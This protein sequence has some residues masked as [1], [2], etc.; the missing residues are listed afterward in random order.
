MT[1]RL[2]VRTILAPGRK[3][4][5]RR[6]SNRRRGLFRGPIGK[7]SASFMLACVSELQRVDVGFVMTNHA[8]TPVV[9]AEQISTATS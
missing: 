4:Q 9:F 8:Q 7:V 1:K 6:D 2:L 3:V 5:R